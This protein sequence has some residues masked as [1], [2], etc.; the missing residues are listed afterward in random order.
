MTE[1]CMVITTAWSEEEAKL[2][3]KTALDLGLS[4][5]VQISAITSIYHWEDKIEESDEYRIVIK[6]SKDHYPKLEEMI[7]KLHSYELPQIIMIN[8][9][10]GSSD[11][12]NWLIQD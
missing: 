11:Y 6:S 2:I 4:K 12:I 9:D 7:K 1:A 3:A 8:I 10:G 5:C